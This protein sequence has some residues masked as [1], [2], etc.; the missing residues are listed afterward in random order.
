M[1]RG[2]NHPAPA[3]PLA[4]RLVAAGLRLTAPRRAVLAVLEDAAAHPT[5]TEVWQLARAR[6]PELGRAT[7]YRTL[8]ALVRL[9]A[10]RPLHL[11]DGSELRYALAVGGHHHVVCADCGAV[12]EFDDCPLGD[13]EATLA[14]RT[15]FRIHGHLLEL[16]GQCPGCR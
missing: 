4:D 10:I 8:E 3:A 11:G 1:I 12:V 7:V 2:V 5:A 16:F 15:G 13:L 9:G 6:W 14:A